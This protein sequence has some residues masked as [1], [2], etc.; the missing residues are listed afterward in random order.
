MHLVHDVISQSMMAEDY[1]E[2]QWREKGDSYLKQ[3]WWWSEQW[4]KEHEQ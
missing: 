2:E 3:G 4:K 1:M